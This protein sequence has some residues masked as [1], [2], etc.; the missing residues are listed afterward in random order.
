MSSSISQAHATGGSFTPSLPLGK[1]K[2]YSDLRENDVVRIPSWLRRSAVV[3]SMVPSSL[4]RLNNA[5]LPFPRNI[6]QKH[7]AD[8]LHTPLMLHM[9]D[10]RSSGTTESCS[11]QLPQVSSSRSR[12]S[13]LTKVNT[14]LRNRTGHAWND[15]AKLYRVVQHSGKIQIFLSPLIPSYF[16][17]KQN[18]DN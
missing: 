12:I 9:P 16:H 7:E 13:G 4:H 10:I 14:R 17:E 18:T 2:Y 5:D 11:P 1:G 15:L 3:Q 8:Q 6:G